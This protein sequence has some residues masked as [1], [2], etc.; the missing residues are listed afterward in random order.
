[1]LTQPLEFVCHLADS[2]SLKVWIRNQ[3][4]WSSALRNCKTGHVWQRACQ[5][6][7]VSLLKMQMSGKKEAWLWLESQTEWCL[8]SDKFSTSMRSSISSVDLLIQSSVSL[9]FTIWS[10]FPTSL[11]KK[12]FANSVISLCMRPPDLVCCSSDRLSIW[13][14]PGYYGKEVYAHTRPYVTCFNH[15]GTL[16]RKSKYLCILM[17]M[18]KSHM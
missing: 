1:M 4:H 11:T 9:L 15:W 2:L 14:V 8:G 6:N 17:Y 13:H 10:W 16:R 18:R 3:F 7:K 12:I 5:G